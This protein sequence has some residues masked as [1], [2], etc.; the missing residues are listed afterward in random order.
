MR[1]DGGKWF[2]LARGDARLLRVLCL[3]GHGSD[4]FLEWQTYQ[5]A[6]EQIERK[7]GVRPTRRALVE[8]VYRIRRALRLAE[9][10]EFLLNG[11]WRGGR[12]RFLLRARG[13]A[14]RDTAE[15]ASRSGGRLTCPSPSPRCAHRSGM[16]AR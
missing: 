9:L 1:I 5:Q 14:K 4:G 12:L 7:T 11:D 8:S 6:P 16:Q 10:N 3:A 2:R 13:G 15:N